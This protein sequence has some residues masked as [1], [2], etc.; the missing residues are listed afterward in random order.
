MRGQTNAHDTADLISF[1]LAEMPIDITV[2]FMEPSKAKDDIISRITSIINLSGITFLHSSGNE[3][4][5]LGSEKINEC[6]ADLVY[7]KLFCHIDGKYMD[8]YILQAAIDVQFCLK[9]PQ[10]LYDF[11]TDNI[12]PPITLFPLLGK[13]SIELLPLARNYFYRKGTR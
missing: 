13:S 4:K 7:I 5:Y 8:V 1:I 6:I 11:S 3:A 2:V 9:L 10:S 12:V